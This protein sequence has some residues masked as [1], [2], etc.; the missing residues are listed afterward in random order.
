[1]KPRLTT[2]HTDV[3]TVSRRIQAGGDAVNVVVHRVQL[4]THLTTV[5]DEPHRPHRV[6]LFRALEV[7]VPLRHDQSRND[8]SQRLSSTGSDAGVPVLEADPDVGTRSKTP[9]AHQRVEV[10]GTGSGRRRRER[11]G[12][13]R[14]DKSLAL[15]SEAGQV[16][17]V[18]VETA[19]G[20]KP[21]VR[22][23]GDDEVILK[24]Q[25]RLARRGTTRSPR[26]HPLAVYTDVLPV[27]VD[28]DLAVAP[29][30]AACYHRGPPVDL[31]AAAVAVYPDLHRYTVAIHLQVAHGAVDNT[32]CKS[33]R[34]GIA[35]MSWLRV[36]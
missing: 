34:T 22:E 15:Q 18:G 11:R 23:R 26:R 31:V 14:A 4:F 9:R 19:G 8:R 6:R 21:A 20:A 32:S 27:N 29:T 10:S 25:R 36:K 2:I 12:A 5:V 30:E 33:K 28:S 1:M 7:L 16:A 24:Q 3:S 17:V 13:G 35:L